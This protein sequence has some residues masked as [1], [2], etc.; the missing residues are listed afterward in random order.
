MNSYN[1][2][3]QRVL[4]LL[5]LDA[6]HLHERI[7]E[8]QKE[9]LKIFSEK[10]TRSHFQEIFFSRWK[11]FGAE[12]LKLLGQDL[13]VALDKFY[14]SVEKMHWYLMQTEDMPATVEDQLDVLLAE[15]DSGYQMFNLYCEG[16]LGFHD[17]E[18]N[19][20][21]ASEEYSS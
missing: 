14:N 21:E 6:E 5:K 13:I 19:I 15:I 17:S 18:E 16:E 20:N 12:E 1:E 7:M 2:N 9:Y 8:R 10:R 3:A 11:T 4:T